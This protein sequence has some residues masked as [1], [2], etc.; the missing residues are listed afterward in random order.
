MHR[1]GIDK[2]GRGF[3]KDKNIIRGL[4]LS[5]G[6]FLSKQREINQL[7]GLGLKQNGLAGEKVLFHKRIKDIEKRL[8]DP[9]VILNSFILSWTQY[10]QLK[11]G[12]TQDEFENNHVLFMTD[13]RDHYIEK[14]FSKLK[15]M[16]Q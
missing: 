8:N 16:S 2:A 13:D 10:P 12:K 1:R 9:A 11:W 4:S 5:F 6:A 15:V 14:L 7:N 3:I